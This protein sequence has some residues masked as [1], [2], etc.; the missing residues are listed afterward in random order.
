M[1][2]HDFLMARERWQ[3]LIL[4]EDDRVRGK[5]APVRTANLFTAGFQWHPK[6]RVSA[7]YRTVMPNEIV[8][9]LGDVGDW[10]V[11][12]DA[13]HRL[14]DALHD[15]GL[16][17]LAA[18]SGGRGT[19]THVWIEPSEDLLPQRRMVTAIIRWATTLTFPNHEELL[20]DGF[21]SD[22]RYWH[23]P[24]GSAQIREFGAPK[25]ASGFLKTLWWRGRDGRA[26]RLPEDRIEAYRRVGTVVPS[27]IPVNKSGI[28]VLHW[29][30]RQA[31][32]RTC[33]RVAECLIYAP[34]DKCPSLL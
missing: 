26:P 10:N 14:W 30:L 11:T 5:L 16:D 34:C 23:P 2:L 22:G 28:G 12:R 3:K 20:D 7:S 32:G 31:F 9:D 19:H 13:T 27:E 8:A 25:S 15:G 6:P 24:P 29:D 18:L 33:P 4:A 17:Y 1:M 21:P